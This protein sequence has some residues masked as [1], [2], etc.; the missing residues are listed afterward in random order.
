LFLARPAD[1][2]YEWR[3]AENAN[4]Y[5]SAVVIRA[6]PDFPAQI[7]LDFRSYFPSTGFVSGYRPKYMNDCHALL[8]SSANCPARAI[9]FS[10]RG[11]RSVATKFFFSRM[12]SEGVIIVLRC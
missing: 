3:A 11:D 7:L 9:A 2:F 4:L 5:L 6:Q 8:C 1:D 10:A 12:L